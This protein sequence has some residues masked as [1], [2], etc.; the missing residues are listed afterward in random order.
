MASLNKLDL[1]TLVSIVVMVFAIIGF[2]TVFWN[3]TLFNKLVMFTI[4]GLLSN[5]LLITILKLTGKM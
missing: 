5:A 1:R 2:L 4:V 3:E